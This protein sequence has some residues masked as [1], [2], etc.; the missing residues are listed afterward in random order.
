MTDTPDSLKQDYIDE[1]A[2]GR[3]AEAQ[4]TLAKRDAMLLAD[5]TTT[6]RLPLIGRERALLDAYGKKLSHAALSQR[7][8]RARTTKPWETRRGVAWEALL[9][10]DDRA[11]GHVCRV[12]ITLDR[13]DPDLEER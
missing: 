2:C 6:E 12:E 5:T 9:T 4:R 7:G 13:L 11:T 3:T 8:V 1:M 10:V